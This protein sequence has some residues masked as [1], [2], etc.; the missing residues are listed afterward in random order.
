M[1]GL[2]SRKSRQSELRHQEAAAP[3][4]TPLRLPRQAMLNFDWK[5][6]PSRD[7][8]GL[9]AARLARRHPGQASERTPMRKLCLFMCGTAIRIPYVRF[10]EVAEQPGYPTSMRTS[11][12]LCSMREAARS[13]VLMTWAIVRWARLL[14]S[15]LRRERRQTGAPAEEPMHLR[16]WL[17][18]FLPT[19]QAGPMPSA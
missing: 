7:G 2:I 15:R 5:I 10:L 4:L 18:I 17:P 3:R 13:S 11:R 9:M 12:S 16:W 14:V 19:R 6:P 8:F 1:A